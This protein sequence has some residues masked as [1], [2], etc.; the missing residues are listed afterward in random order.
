MAENEKSLTDRIVDAWF[1]KDKTFVYLTIL[2]VLGLVLRII[3]A[4]NLEVAADDMHFAPGAINFLS[5]GKLEYWDQSAGLWFA[6][7]DISYKILGVTQFASRFAPVLF[8]MLLIFVV[9]L[10]AKELFKDNKT[11]LIASLLVA[12]SPFHIKSM[13]AEMDVMAMFF[14]FLSLFLFLRALN[15]NADKRLLALSA[16]ALGLAI[17]T[18]VYP[19]LFIPG[20]LIFWFYKNHK[21]KIQERGSFYKTLILFLAVVFIFCLPALTHNYLL[22]KEKGIM[23]V[24]FSETL[25]IKKSLDMYSWAAGSGAKPDFAG[26]FLGRS[27][28]FYNGMPTSLLALYWVFNADPLIFILGI[29]G[30][31]LLWKRK[32]LL[33]LMGL[34]FIFPFAYLAS[35]VLLIKHYLFVSLILTIPAAATLSRISKLIRLRY[36]AVIIIIFS[37]VYLG[38]PNQTNAHSIYEKSTIAKLMDFKQNMNPEAI[39][40]VDSRVYRGEMT[41][42]FSDRHYLEASYINEFF[43]MQE[44]QTKVSTP[45][46]YIECARDDC[47]W[48]TVYNQPEFNA[49]MENMSAYFKSISSKVGAIS[50]SQG[51]YFDV[52]KTE[53]NLVPQSA[54]IVDLT[55]NWWLYPLG[56]NKQISPIFDDYTP[57]SFSGIL[58]NNIAHAILYFSIA[59]AFL[60]ILVV[61]YLLIKEL[62]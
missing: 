18:K 17:Y 26:F 28:A 61:L 13:T 44:N 24:R 11:A 32:D 31:I 55:H 16:I 21:E 15:N 56:Y 53:M 22:Y 29:L 1:S 52:Y 38:F 4:M 14:V 2:L 59:A 6:V 20:M 62:S 54:S 46:Y 42:A 7:T 39:I 27:E 47:G 30:L 50:D 12:I 45:V 51:E 57:K 10:L 49:T 35:L 33:L 5:S 23:D 40:L 9:F 3:A 48:G 58:L 19:L 60:S 36:I 8:G 25:G 34:M 41:W 43:K 37:L